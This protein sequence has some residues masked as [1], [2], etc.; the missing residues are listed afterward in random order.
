M[1]GFD[2]D[3]ERNARRTPPPPPGA[4]PPDM[5]LESLRAAN[6]SL[7]AR[8]EEAEE[9]IHAIRQGAVDAFVLEETGRHKVYTLEGADRP[10]QVFVE[11][12]QQGV[13]TLLTDGTVLYANRRLAEL[14]RVSNETLVGKAVRDHVVPECLAAYD[15]L[16]ERGR[17]GVAR[18]ELRLRQG[19]GDEVPAYLTFR[20]LPGENEAVLGLFVTDLTREKQTESLAAAQEALREAD[21]RKNEFLAMLAHELRNP[22][23]PIRNAVSILRVTGGNPE[24]VRSMCCMLERQVGQMVRLVDDLLDVSRITRDR[25]ELRRE[26]VE[27]A[28]VLNQAVESVRPHFRNGRHTISL[29][30]PEEP[31]WLDADP[32]RLTQI[33][34]NLLD[35]AC[36][37][38]EP[39]GRV[40]LSAETAPA[41]AGNI[42]APAGTTGEVVVRVRDAGIGIPAEQ[43]S[44][45]FEMFTQVDTSLERRSTGLGIGLT[46]VSRLVELH[47]GRVEARSEGPGTGSEFVVTLPT[48]GPPAVRQ[49]AREG[50]RPMKR[51]RMLVVDDNRDSAES[52]ALLLKLTGHETHTALDGEAALT[53]AQETKPDVV[54]LDI[55]MPKLNGYDACRKIRSEPWGQSMILI[56]QTGW[57]QEDDRR[58]T[59]EAGFDGH[60]VKPVDP[61]DLMKMV[62]RLSLSRARE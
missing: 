28:S 26:R 52:L 3:R 14:L 50:D 10:Y 49:D 17:G 46:L 48:A 32:V 55:G 37:Y 22:M 16:L 62:A 9:T 23:A 42:A 60:V 31:V 58:R 1:N 51:Y 54:L 6:R 21:R 11:E 57:G 8:L 43:L 25:I 36:K 41:R 35:N 59:E 18:G 12:M 15:D 56:A 44:R 53:A 7:S 45:I 38:M 61:D 30:L 33:F 19:H 40:W 20:L 2:A 34:T 27:L 24:S 13:A 39:G 5:T 47:G 4:P 29:D